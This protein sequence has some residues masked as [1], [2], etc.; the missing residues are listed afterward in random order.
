MKIIIL[1]TDKSILKW[2]SLPAKI[3]RLE[4]VLKVWDISVETIDSIPPIVN[5]RV[6][7]NEKMIWLAMGA[8]II[9]API[10]SWFL[11]NYIEFKQAFRHDIELTIKETLDDYEF[12][13]AK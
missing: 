8:I 7:F 9:L 13:V 12:E 3:A 6:S 4:K 2:K 5:G 10:F 1:S 11:L